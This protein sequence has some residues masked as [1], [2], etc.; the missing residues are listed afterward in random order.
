MMD[1]DDTPWYPT[2]RQFRQ[3]RREDWGEVFDRIAG[4][5]ARTVAGK[6]K[7]ENPSSAGRPGDLDST[8]AAPPGTA[9]VPVSF[10]ELVDKITILEI[11]S[12]RINDVRKAAN[13]RSELELL[14]A[15]LAR[16]RPLSPSSTA[17]R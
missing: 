2:A 13:I 9:L 4:E 15:A 6:A 16:F 11:K 5:L 1:R 8:P 3:A 7:P 12:E 10:G 14:A 17:D